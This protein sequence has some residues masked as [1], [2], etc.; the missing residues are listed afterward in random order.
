M[1]K[2][3]K[4]KKTKWKKNKRARGQRRRAEEEGTA[5]RSKEGKEKWRAYISDGAQSSL[6]FLP[7][8][9]AV[10]LSDLSFPFLRSFISLLSLPFPLDRIPGPFPST[11]APPPPP[12]RRVHLVVLP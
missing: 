8:L 3:K 5:A 1:K 12:L 10:L 7:L 11:I 4:K 2:T 6:F 9:S